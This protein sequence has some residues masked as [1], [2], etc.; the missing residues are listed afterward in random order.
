MSPPTKTLESSIFRGSGKMSTLEFPL[1]SRLR[2]S[3]PLIV[4]IT[5]RCPPNMLESLV[6]KLLRQIQDRF[7]DILTW[8]IETIQPL[9][10]TRQIGNWHMNSAH[11]T[12]FPSL[13]FSWFQR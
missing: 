7:C 13:A 2:V 10:P 11:S 4:F 1:Q 5:V 6:E 9:I 12:S 3:M 8:G